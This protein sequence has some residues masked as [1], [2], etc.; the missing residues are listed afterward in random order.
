M[1]EL[2]TTEFAELHGCSPKHV[3]AK[4]KIKKI[5]GTKSL[6]DRRVTLLTDEEQAELEPLINANRKRTK[7]E[8]IAD[9]VG[10]FVEDEAKPFENTALSFHIED[11]ESEILALRQDAKTIA[12]QT[13][14]NFALFRQANLDRVR[15]LARRDAGEALTVYQSE[16]QAVLTE[17]L[18]EVYG[19]DSAQAVTT[20]TT[21]K[22]SVGQS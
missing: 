6:L 14:G 15:A 12:T 2:S 20:S 10:E 8:P 19:V 5:K 13:R 21:V 16:Y 7:P 17:D 22:K 11:R 18:G 4:M 3:N 9:V 1:A